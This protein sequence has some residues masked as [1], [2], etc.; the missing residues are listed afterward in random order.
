MTEIV[1]FDLD[2]TLTEVHSPWQYIHE[3][4]GLW[5]GIGDRHLAE[6]RAG[7]IGY[8]TWFDLDVEMWRGFDSAVLLGI[9]DAIEIRSSVPEVLAGLRSKA[10]PAVILSSGFAHVARRVEK[11]A[12]FRFADVR[13]NEMVFGPSGRLLGVRLAVSGE[14]N[15]PRSKK[16]LLLESC[17]RFGIKPENALAIGDS[18]SDTPMFEAAGFSIGL[19]PAGD[20]GADVHLDPRMLAR[21]LDYV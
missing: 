10:V 5:T 2:G 3:Q 1:F 13:A 4:L 21:M 14:K 6:W 15:D 16:S 17:A 20:I 19:A 9:L 8:K 11:A 18:P 12:S 7:R